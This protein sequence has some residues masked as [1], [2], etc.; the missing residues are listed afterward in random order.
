MS[1]P[2]ASSSSQLVTYS[3]DID[4]TQTEGFKR[5][6]SRYNVKNA[7]V[8]RNDPR[9]AYL[10]AETVFQAVKGLG[11]TLCSFDGLSLDDFISSG[12]VAVHRR[13]K[14]LSLA[15]YYAAQM[16]RCMQKWDRR[17]DQGPNS[18]T[19]DTCRQLVGIVGT[20]LYHSMADVQSV[21]GRTVDPPLSRSLI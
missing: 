7:R 1:A 21:V 10:S 6:K 3:Q 15:P 14:R 12:L 17:D 18:E 19:I 4:Y 20:G 5:F 13:L 2:N 11:C 8:A 9:G 16:K